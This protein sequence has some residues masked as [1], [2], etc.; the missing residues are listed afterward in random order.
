MTVKNRLTRNR[1][2][3]DVN[4]ESLYRVVLSNN[5]VAKLPQKYVDCDRILPGE[6]EIR[7][8]MSTGQNECMERCHRMRITDRKQEFSAGY[9]S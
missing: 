5:I 8:D 2:N 6:V 1:P 9:D 4:I 3:I 7:G